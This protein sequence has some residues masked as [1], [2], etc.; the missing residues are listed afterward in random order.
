MCEVCDARLK[1]RRGFMT[2]AAG[3]FTGLAVGS[4]PAMAAGGRP[5]R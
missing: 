1:G 3:L 2:A 4:M 5:H